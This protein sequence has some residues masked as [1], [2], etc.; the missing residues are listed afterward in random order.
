MSFTKV[1]LIVTVSCCA[2]LSISACTSTVNEG[3][4]VKDHV[5]QKA[6]ANES[7]EQA[8]TNFN[9]AFMRDAAKSSL[10]VY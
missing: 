2:L 10:L 5:D 8:Q 6:A 9:I 3:N 7:T 1:T 4:A